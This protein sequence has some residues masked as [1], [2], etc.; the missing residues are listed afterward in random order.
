LRRLILHVFPELITHQSDLAS[1]GS[2]FAS[3]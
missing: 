2:L 1:L 3:V